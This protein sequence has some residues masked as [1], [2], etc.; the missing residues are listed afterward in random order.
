MNLT[1]ETYFKFNK[2]AWI[3]NIVVTSILAVTSLYLFVALLYH[4]LKL[5]K[6][7]KNFLDL[8]LE[9][10]FRVL[11]KYTCISIAAASI[12]QNLSSTSLLLV[13]GDYN[14]VFSNVSMLHTNSSETAC[15]VLI[16]FI[17][18]GL[19]SGS[20]LVILFL[21]F[22]QSVFYVHSS[23]K[24]LNNKCLKICSFS[25]M[26][27]YYL[28]FVSALIFSFINFE[29][30]LSQT[31]CLFGQHDGVDLSYAWL[32]SSSFMQLAL[33][34][35]FIY[36]MLKRSQWM[37]DQHD[38]RNS[39]LMRRVKKAIVLASICLV[40]DVSSFLVIGL[41]VSKTSNRVEYPYSINLMVNLMVAIV[42]FDYWKILLWPWKTKCLKINFQA[43]GTISSKTLSRR[44]T[45]TAYD[46][47]HLTAKPSFSH[48]C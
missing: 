28:A 36:P 44:R 1:D 6:S 11:S 35:L 39:R 5:Q 41:L 13:E 17:T 8:D 4:Q 40:T 42:C 38:E 43:G 3:G 9:K 20:A 32:I 18:L 46:G 7:K 31:G 15:N 2:A 23:L 25:V 27:L 12:F 34:G 30:E 45:N 26:A 21:W 48:H 33:L 10:K 22:R 16:L 29:D 47:F 14:A 37:T 24:V 19:G